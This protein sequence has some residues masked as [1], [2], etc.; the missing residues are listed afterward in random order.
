MNMTEN[1]VTL[2]RLADRLGLLAAAGDRTTS[3]TSKAGD[4]R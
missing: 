2:S 4:R 3:P 1:G